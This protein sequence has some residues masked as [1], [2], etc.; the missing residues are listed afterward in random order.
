[1]RVT[2]QQAVER[3]G[4]TL[5]RLSADLEIPFQTVYGWQNMNKVPKPEYLDL[6][7]CYLQ[8]QIGEIL[9]PENPEYSP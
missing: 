7:C 5:Y 2:I 6:I 8:C 1:M 3:R 4:K 9:K